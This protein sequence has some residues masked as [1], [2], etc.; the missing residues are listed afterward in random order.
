FDDVSTAWGLAQPHYSN[1]IAYVDLDGDGAL[2]MVV[3]NI[4][5]E[6]LLYRNT[7]CDKDTVTTHYLQV[8]YKGD[9][10]NREG[11]GAIAT[12]WYD[13]GKQQTY[14]NNPYRGYL[15]TMENITHFGLG[16]I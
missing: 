16:N 5:D 4:N 2:D 3:N 12:I 13:H 7:S 8:R 15:S 14:E 10:H 6:A 11:L 9:S 1:G